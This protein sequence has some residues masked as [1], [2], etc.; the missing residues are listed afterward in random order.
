[1]VRGEGNGVVRDSSLG[2]YIG[3]SRDTKDGGDRQDYKDMYRQR[4]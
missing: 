1:M 3:V 4:V 2:E